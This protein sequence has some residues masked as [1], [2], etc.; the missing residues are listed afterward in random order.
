[1]SVRDRTI[2]GCLVLA[3]AIGLGWALLVSPKRAQATKLESQI[4]SEQ[5]QLAGVRTQ[6]A[7]GEA[8]EGAFARSYT[9]LVRLG[10][11]VP[12][13]DNTPSLIL[14]LQK[15]AKSTGVNF[16]SLTFNAGSS[17]AP[18][19]TTSSSSAT[20]SATAALPPGATVGPAGF[21]IEPFTFEFTGNF[22]H[23]A[24]FLN[25]LQK[26][27]VANNKSLSVSG[28]LMTLDSI[29]L[30]PGQGGFPQI[31]ATIGA[32]TFLLPSAQG[33]TAGA[34]PAGPGSSST[35]TVSAP[36]SSASSST[37]PAVVTAPI[38]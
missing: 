35:Q 38:R 5:S 7:A 14:Q 26:F 20:Q 11:A 9:S 36:S 29:N 12:T 25:K 2:A 6:L 1:M 16:D 4:N 31:D 33:L 34:T 15:A 23:L 18:A 27:V 22:F 37:A 21:P 32:T 24:S 3:A 28:R 17:S 10:E 19:P 8:A 13:D 30:G